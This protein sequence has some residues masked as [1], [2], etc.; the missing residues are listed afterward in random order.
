VILAC[1]LLH[2]QEEKLEKEGKY[3]IHNEKHE[4][5]TSAGEV[6]HVLYYSTSCI[7]SDVLC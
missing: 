1:G 4:K 3:W 2:A 5:I 6:R 7:G